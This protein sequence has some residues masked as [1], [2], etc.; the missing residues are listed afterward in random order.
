MFDLNF[1]GICLIY[2]DL[3]RCIEATKQGLKDS[4]PSKERRREDTFAFGT[5]ATILTSL[6]T[7]AT[8]IHIYKTITSEVP[9]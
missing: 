1:S 3:S 9:I 6:S 7:K 4:G 5:K 2:H 8:S